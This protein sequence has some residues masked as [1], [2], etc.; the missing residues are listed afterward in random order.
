MKALVFLLPQLSGGGA[1]KFVL[2]LY[3]ALEEHQGYECHIVLL[4][5]R[6]EHQVDGDVRIHVV[7]GAGS[8]SKAGLQRL[9]YRKRLAARVD[10]Y[11]EDNIG[12]DLPVLSNM[13][14][15]D[16]IMSE[17]RLR[18][19]HVIHSA[20]S[21]SLLAGKRWL[22]RLIIRHNINRVYGRHPMI[23]VSEGARNSFQQSFH[24]KTEQH[25]IYNPVP[26]AD[27]Q[28]LSM[29]ETLLPSEGDYIIHV[30]RFNR[31]K[32]HDRLL[33]AFASL[34]TKA[35]LM[36]IGDGKLQN[37]IQSQIKE[38]HLQERVVLAGFIP[39]PYPYIRQAKVLALSSDY[40]GLPTVILEAA[41][42][43]TP[44]VATDCPGGIREILPSDSAS[45]VPMT[46][47]DGLARCLADALLR[48]EP[49]RHSLP[50]RFNSETIAYQYAELFKQC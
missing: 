8:V 16:K 29:A 48:P 28:A 47:P 40:E 15:A 31:E 21:E 50:D 27:I 41:C 46:Q 30:G 3:R 34:D 9:T 12:H 7:P 10:Q 6:I 23:F 42:L 45:L 17:S 32:R 5:N 39:N 19:Y 44:I 4:E 2:N 43:G 37:A 36:L 20:Y 24:R 1:E 38:L 18:V 14:H 33:R 35:Q 49:Y 25:V 22:R 11:I 13:H 26:E